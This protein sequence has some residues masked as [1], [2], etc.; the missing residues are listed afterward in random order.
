MESSSEISLMVKPHGAPFLWKQ[1]VL[2]KFDQA[3]ATNDLLE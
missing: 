3:T 1:K 2:Q